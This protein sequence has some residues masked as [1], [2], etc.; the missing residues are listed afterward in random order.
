VDRCPRGAASGRLELSN[1]RHPMSDAVR[2]LLGLWRQSPQRTSKSSVADACV[3][4]RGDVGL[5]HVRHVFFSAPTWRQALVEFQHHIPTAG[6]SMNRGLESRRAAGPWRQTGEPNRPGLD[7]PALTDPGADCTTNIGGLSAA[8]HPWR[9]AQPSYPARRAA[10][11]PQ[12]S[13]N[14]KTWANVEQLEFGLVSA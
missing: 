13:H 7:S 2:L 5:A 11:T 6:S 3:A 9:A 10:D 8:Q 1:G 4:L 12:V 14:L